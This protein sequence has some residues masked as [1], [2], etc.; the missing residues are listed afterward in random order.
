[1]RVASPANLGGC[2]VDRRRE[3][4]AMTLLSRS[5]SSTIDSADSIFDGDDGVDE[6]RDLSLQVDDSKTI[7]YSTNH[8]NR[9]KPHIEGLRCDFK[10]ILLTQ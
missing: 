8:R 1:M 3:P 7:A 6:C 9:N 4:G 5:M 10:L 2:S